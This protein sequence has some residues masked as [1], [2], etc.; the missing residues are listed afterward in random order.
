MARTS[1]LV[2][3]LL[4]VVGAAPAHAG[5]ALLDLNQD[6]F[7]PGDIVRAHS[8]VWLKSSMGRLEDGPYFAYLSRQAK[9]IPPPFP[10]DALRVAPVVVE[11]R[12]T[13]E[14][15]DASVEFALPRVVPG[16]YWL[17]ICNDPCTITLGDLMPTELL[18]A[19]SAADGPLVML[20]ERLLDRI[21]ALRILLGSR[22]LDARPDSLRGR[23][24]SLERDVTRLIADVDALKS[25]AR[26]APRDPGR[27]DSDAVPVVLALVVPAAALG[28]LL[29]R[30]S[31][32]AR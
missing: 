18:V 7:V 28:L 31:Y 21:R 16:R 29:G 10:E 26:T 15:G 11:P 25:A 14:H 9:G 12:P 22:V 6:Y 17:T 23:I 30:R 27:A 32:R 8:S 3:A 2:A 5:G 19:G 20:R 24:I 4:L 1:S 13:G